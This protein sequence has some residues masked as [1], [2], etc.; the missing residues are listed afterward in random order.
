MENFESWKSLEDFPK[1]LISNKGNIKSLHRNIILK[2][3]CM[4]DGYRRVVLMKNGERN[5]KMVHRVVWEAFKGSIPEGRV[6]NHKDEDKSNNSLH[7]LELC[8]MQYNLEYS[9]SRHYIVTYPDGGEEKI[10]NLSK[11]CN[12][13]GLHIGAMSEMATKRK[14]Y[15]GRSLRKHHKGFSCRYEKDEPE[16]GVLRNGC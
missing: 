11:F 7:N 6:I 15:D 3:E 1:Y 9:L 16:K 5:R 10:F 4:K 12:E 8:N 13:H 2:Q 14:R